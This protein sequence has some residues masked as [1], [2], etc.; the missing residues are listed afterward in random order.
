[1]QGSGTTTRTTRPA[2]LFH[3][4]LMGIL[5]SL[6]TVVAAL[7]ATDR[8][9]AQ[10]L[11]DVM[12]GDCSLCRPESSMATRWEQ[13]GRQANERDAYDLSSSNNSV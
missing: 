1:M 11:Q 13:H 6:G 9:A 2:R 8:L 12:A 3:A 7:T 5:T 4:D 10:S